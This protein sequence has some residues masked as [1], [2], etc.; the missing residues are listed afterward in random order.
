MAGLI[1]AA[2]SLFEPRAGD[3]AATGS[4]LNGT[5]PVAAP[6]TQADAFDANS[7]AYGDFV[8]AQR[9]DGVA[10]GLIDPDTGWPTKAGLE[11]ASRQLAQSMLLGTTA[12]EFKGAAFTAFHGS[13]H[14]FDQFQSSAIGTG[15]GAQAYGHGLYF[16]DQ[17]AT[18]KTYRDALSNQAL[19]DGKP[20]SAIP[21][22]SDLAIAQHH[23]AGDVANGVSAEEAIATQAQGLRDLAK[24]YEDYPTLLN[25]AEQSKSYRARA[26]QI[27]AL[28]PASF[29]KNPGSMYEVSINADP[30]HF[31]DWDKPLSE[32]SPHVQEALGKV[33]YG[34]GDHSH[35]IAVQG[36]DVNAQYSFPTA[37][38]AAAEAAKWRELGDHQVQG[39]WENTH[40]E[41]WTGAKVYRDMQA[42]PRNRTMGSEADALKAAG[43]PGIRYLDGGSRANGEGTSN[44][45]VFDAN[46]IAILRK[47]GIAGLMAGAA[48]AG[49]RGSTQ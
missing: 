26:D 38:E 42:D 9:A 31:L 29:S 33:G 11:D 39:P 45:V 21:M 8:A 10:K 1:N 14:S 34:P 40:E 13:P 24:M 25:A 37:V 23:V 41:P 5:P 12:P 20:L 30:A 44:H 3:A 49:G 2:P 17:E 35:S 18:A 7:K 48:G 46:T 19:V 27:E 6:P 28:N 47:Y 4:F 16:A 43:I 15:E 32:Q 22:D 36:P